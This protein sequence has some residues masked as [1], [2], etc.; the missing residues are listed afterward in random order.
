MGGGAGAAKPKGTIELKAGVMSY[1]SVTHKCE[2][3][4]RKGLIVVKKSPEGYF[5]LEFQDASTGQVI[6]GPDMIFEGDVTFTKVKQ[7]E[8]RTYVMTFKDTNRRKFYWF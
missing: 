1:D 4:R 6:E 3:D 8:D 7:S 5:T 2:A